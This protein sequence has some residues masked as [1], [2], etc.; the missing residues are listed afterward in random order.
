MC[1]AASLRLC[2]LFWKASLCLQAGASPAFEAFCGLSLKE[3]L[4]SKGCQRQATL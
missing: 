4:V 2:S 1:Q 3:L